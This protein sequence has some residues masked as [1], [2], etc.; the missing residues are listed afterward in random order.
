MKNPARRPSSCRAGQRADSFLSLRESLIVERD[1]L[2]A[3]PGHI[4]VAEDTAL[5]AGV[6]PD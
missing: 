2:A 1:L 5:F 3:A 4:A 6:T